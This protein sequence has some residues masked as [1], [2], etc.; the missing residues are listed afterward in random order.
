MSIAPLQSFPPAPSQRSENASMR[1]AHTPSSSASNATESAQAISGTLAKQ[2]ASIAKNVSAPYESSSDVVE[3][4]Q[5]PDIKDQIVIQYLNP[6][7]DV[8][9]QVPSSE[10]LN[11]E[12]G[13]AQEFQQVQSL[14]AIENA[15]ATGSRGEKNHGD[16]L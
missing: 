8:V 12:R 4:H 16:Q 5:D 7:K 14:G 1:S 11:V 13:I 15:A 2:Q 6:A 3:V 10:E 9:L